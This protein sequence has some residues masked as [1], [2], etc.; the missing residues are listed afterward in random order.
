MPGPRLGLTR[1]SQ[2]TE[3]TGD[4]WGLPPTAR[5]RSS[6][7]RARPPC[8]L[9]PGVAERSPAAGDRLA[10]LADGLW[11][12][13]IGLQAGLLLR[14]QSPD[15]SSGRGPCLEDPPQSLASQ[16]KLTR[17]QAIWASGASHCAVL[18][19]ASA[20]PC[21]LVQGHHH[22]GQPGPQG[23]RPPTAWLCPWL[24]PPRGRCL[25][26]KE[27]G[28]SRQAVSKTAGPRSWFPC[29][30]GHMPP[31][32][33]RCT[34]RPRHPH[35]PGQDLGRGC[36]D[37]AESHQQC[38]LKTSFRN[39]TETSIPLPGPGGNGP[40]ADPYPER[41]SGRQNTPQ[42]LGPS[43]VQPRSGSWAPHPMRVTW[44]AGLCFRPCFPGGR[45]GGRSPERHPQE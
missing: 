43:S 32:L 33:P 20:A 44:P 4:G 34:V 18:G 21:C 6:E 26:S 1:I 17:P 8:G 39:K 16:A 3:S 25:G 15:L 35:W 38:P 5:P 28:G 23:T 37:S 29:P 30:T 40:A 11:V 36:G 10:P 42:H 12:L 19:P 27:S 7:N 13:A 9:G 22:L 45:G 31:V 14:G 2:P 41:A 24:G